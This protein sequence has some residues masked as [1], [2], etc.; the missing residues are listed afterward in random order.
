MKRTK[1][2]CAVMLVF[3]IS[4]STAAC[5]SKEKSAE[6]N[7]PPVISGV[8]DRTVEAGKEFNAMENVTV[9]DK[10]DDNIISGLMIDSTP[11]LD[12]KNGTAIPDKA[13][14][15]EITYSVTDGGGLTA[16]AYATLTVTRQTSEAVLYR[17]FDFSTEHQV[18]NR[19]WET[20]IA[21][22]A[23]AT[24]ATKQGAYVFDIQSPG[25]GD[26]DIQL[27]KSNF[28]LKAA[29]YRIRVWAKA[30]VP[31]Y[32]HIIARDEAAEDWQTFGGAYNVVIGEEIT[33]LE[34]NFTAA[35][36]GSAEIMIHLG[37]ITPNQEN[38]DDTTPENFTVT[39]DK[40]EIYEV[41]GKESQKTA[42]SNNFS[43]N[44]ETASVAAGDGADASMSLEDGAVVVKIA[45]YPTEGGVWSIKS[46]L[47]LPGITIEQGKKY[48]Y[49]FKLMAENTQ[50]GEL[51]V[52]S[53]SLADQQR[54]CFQSVFINGEEE[55][56]ISG[57]FVAESSVADP[58]IRMQIG[59]PSEGVAS[60]TI[61]IDDV[62]FGVMEGNLNTT[63]TIDAFTAF[64]K[65]TE[66][67]TNA[68]FPWL[69]FNGSDEEA[70]G[71]GTIWTENGSLFYRIDQGGVTDWHNKLVCG[72][73]ENPLVLEA[74][75]Y[76]TV[77]ITA[78]ASK[79]VSCGFF[80]NPLGGWDPRITE[81]MDITTEEKT[82]SFETTDTLI[83]DMSFEMLFQFGS[84]KTAQ[85][86]DVTIEIS[87]VR[88]LQK[89]IN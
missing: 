20:R 40:I 58:V 50:A 53:G 4:F 1:K 23:A 67:E 52:E 12:F 47:A 31:T 70:E 18:D 80:L 21:E 38:P 24:A 46:D 29:D 64:G 79:P 11:A 78:K 13:G 65:G 84:E 15:Y 48:Y 34:L 6:D 49:S 43:E 2:L 82:F 59:N 85:L 56:I 45:A 87:S 69:T 28:E 55:T 32:A 68:E 33:P 27:I 9:V 39:I 30:S 86:G 7:T 8:M 10:E 44:A 63:K 22:G 41:T 60:N 62:E 37:K 77:E 51:L 42:Y 19:G 17:E 5:S 61:M 76:Y 16:E 83:T 74:D 88:I 14:T 71:V 66:N 25:L 75:S 81:S 3:L 57:T 54:A 73:T 89:S 26:G 36:A 35:G 72:Y